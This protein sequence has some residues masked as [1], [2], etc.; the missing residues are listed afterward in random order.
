M[1]QPIYLDNAATSFPKPPQVTEAMIHYMNEVGAN[2]GRSG[3]QLSLEASR[4][5]QH[6]RDNLATLFNISDTKRIV[7]TMNVTE[8]LNTVIYGFL[9]AG[10][11][12]IISAMEHNSVLRP[13]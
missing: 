7:F 8:A 2:P 9:N 4:V 11:H 12:V 6:T 5:V 1:R 10:D 13:L 3:H